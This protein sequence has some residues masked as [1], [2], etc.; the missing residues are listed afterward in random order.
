MEEAERRHRI[1]DAKRRT[2]GIDKATLDAQVEEKK[3]MEE[4]E[5]E[6][7]ANFDQQAA[8]FNNV[9]KM[10]ELEA[11]QKRQEL[12]RQFKTYSMLHNNKAERSNADIENPPVSHAPLS[13]GAEPCGP[14]SAQ[15]FAGEDMGREARIK[16]Q[17][18]Q[19]RD[20]YEQ[21]VFEKNIAS[22]MNKNAD[23]IFTTQNDLAAQNLLEVEKAEAAMRA[24][25]EHS[26]QEYNQFMESSKRYQ[27]FEEKERVEIEK[28]AHVDSQLASNFLN[29]STSWQGNGKILFTEYKGEPKGGDSLDA[30]IMSREAQIEQKAV[31]EAAKV[32]EEKAYV[33]QQ[34]MVRRTLVESQMKEKRLKREMQESIVRENMAIAAGR[35]AKD[36]YAQHSMYTNECSDL[37]WSQFGTSTR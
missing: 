27:K 19:L 29:E 36:T 10:Q 14:A 24:E 18:L 15:I 16:A 21:Q 37:F 28:Q 26:R 20:W 2:I 13:A 33:R 7:N 9:I 6:R 35:K 23:E 30:M 32:K 5:K 17:K 31:V 1:F 22:E 11:R 34:E 25:L 3:M 4:V 12:E 8:Y